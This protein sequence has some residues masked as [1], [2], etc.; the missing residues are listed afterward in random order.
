[1]KSRL[2]D[3]LKAELIGE[4]YD[5]N[6]FDNI[7]FEKGF[8]E[9]E[10]DEEEQVKNARKYTNGKFSIWV[11]CDIEGNSIYIG[12][13]KGVT[14]QKGE[15]TATDPFASYKDLEKVQNWFKENGKYHYWLAGWM[16]ANLGR[17]VEDIMNLKWSQIIDDNGNF[18]KQIRI[19]EKKTN[20]TAVLECTSFLI[21]RVKEYCDITEIVP[22][23]HYDENIFSVGT[24]AMRT[25]LKNAVRETGISGQI[26]CHSYRK[27]FACMQLELH[28]DDIYAMR[29]VMEMMNHSSEEM[30]RKYLKILDD[31]K[32]RY[33]HDFSDYMDSMYNGTGFEINH[34]PVI[35][36]KT[37]DLREVLIVAM[38]KDYSVESLNDLLDMVEKLRLK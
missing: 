23:Q 31:K 34:A 2:I 14:K 3:K 10:E 15:E 19:R 7:L 36:L 8:S 11:E 24:A 28:P 35:T 17:R 12:N 4:I 29:M 1:M 16:M 30:T 20:K 37:N 33:Q 9:L 27:Y 22:K 5:L 21:N 18:N 6:E 13:I 26:S 38:K 25:A 32:T